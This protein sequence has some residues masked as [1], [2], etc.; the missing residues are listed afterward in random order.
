M[1]GLLCHNSSLKAVTT[2][3]PSII[4]SEMNQISDMSDNTSWIHKIILHRLIFSGCGSLNVLKNVELGHKKAVK[5][6]VDDFTKEHMK[7]FSGMLHCG[8]LKNE[9]CSSPCNRNVMYHVL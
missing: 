2:C 6:L 5:S 3:L 9:V 8:N 7:I 4:D 1:L